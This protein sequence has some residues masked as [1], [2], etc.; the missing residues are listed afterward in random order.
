[1]GNEKTDSLYIVFSQIMKL[2]YYRTYTLFEKIGIYPGQHALLFALSKNNGQ[3]QKKLSEELCIKPATIT[4]TI[5]RMEKIGLVERKHD[6]SDQR[7]YRVY[8]TEKGRKICTELI[9]MMKVID[10]ECFGNFTYEE[11]IIMRRLLM[12]VRDNL[13]VACSEKLKI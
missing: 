12:Q 7:I 10:R 4:V 5:K 13:S 3:S 1:M 11:K 8:I 9:R 6:T 2:H